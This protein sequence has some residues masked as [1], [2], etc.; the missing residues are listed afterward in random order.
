M[1]HMHLIYILHYFY[2]IVYFSFYRSSFF[3]ACRT[4]FITP[5]KASMLVMKSFSFY[6][7]FIDRGYFS[8]DKGFSA[9]FPFAFNNLKK[10]ACSFTLVQTRNLLSFYLCSLVYKMFST[11]ILLLA[12]IQVF[13]LMDRFEQ[14]LAWFRLGRLE[15]TAI[16]ELRC[17]IFIKFGK[18]IANIFPS[19]CFF[20]FLL[21]QG[22]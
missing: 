8:L 6:F 1:L 21:L 7:S 17:L 5:Y 16:F 10:I 4:S 11:P 20:F 19:I 22:I 13:L 15:I 9:Q 2:N 14:L 3:S 18:Y 12:T